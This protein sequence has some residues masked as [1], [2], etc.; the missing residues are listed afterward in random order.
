V[1]ANNRGVAAVVRHVVL[2]VLTATCVYNPWSTFRIAAGVALVV[3][4][5]ELARHRPGAAAWG[6]LGLAGLM[7]F[8]A[9]WS[10]SPSLSS[11]LG[12]DQLFVVALFVAISAGIDSRRGLLVVGTGYLLGCALL[13]LRLVT[14]NDLLNSARLTL[15]TT[16]RYTVEGFN[17]NYVSYTLASGLAVVV[18]LATASP[19]IRVPLLLTGLVF[20]AG[21]FATGT[22]G[23]FYAAMGLVA[24]WLVPSRW[25][26]PAFAGLI[27]AICVVA[28]AIVTGVF[29]SQVR[30]WLRADGVRES[31]DLN[32]RLLVWQIA[33]DMLMAH[34]FI[35]EGAGTITT[36]GSNV[37]F[38]HNA[39]LD[40]GSGTGLIGM[41]LFLLAL[42]G[43]L[44]PV[45]R[46]G[47]T[48][49]MLVGAFL[50]VSAPPLL[51]GYWYQSPA[52]WILLAIFSRVDLLER[53]AD[54]FE[55]PMMALAG[56][57]D[58]PRRAGSLLPRAR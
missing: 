1:S 41:G 49:M 16:T 6:A 29:D 30:T 33:R 52:L 26:R 13:L 17:Q 20:C 21:I 44:A 18:L 10:D 48:E 40:V 43:V 50:A 37:I 46:L 32:G 57:A 19:R 28:A 56:P 22:R 4:A 24:W 51:S 34:P 15:S 12:R 53:R 39:L 23:A 9:G 38:A 31:G 42:W 2:A 3:A 55:H 45:A 11:Q 27:V 7:Y 47:T 54:S 58:P 5:G 35:G 14:Q 8:S 25:R 36:E